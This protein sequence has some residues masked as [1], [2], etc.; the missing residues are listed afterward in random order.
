[1]EEHCAGVN[2]MEGEKEKEMWRGRVVQRKGRR[3]SMMK[4]EEGRG[5]GEGENIVPEGVGVMERNG[6]VEVDECEMGKSKL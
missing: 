5:E 3:Q 2:M 1:M 6:E 4:K